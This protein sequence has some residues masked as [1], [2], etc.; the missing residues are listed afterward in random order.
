MLGSKLDNEMEL[1]K[2]ESKN[3]IR[4]STETLTVNEIE[5]LQK[6]KQNWQSPFVKRVDLESFSHGIVKCS[7]MRTLDCEGNGIDG[8]MTINGKVAYPVDNVIAWIETRIKKKKKGKPGRNSVL[9]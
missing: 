8:K 2:K 1:Q 3:M 6:L 4:R 5:L 7:S 9:L